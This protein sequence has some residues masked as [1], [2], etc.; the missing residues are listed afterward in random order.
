MTAADVNIG[1]GALLETFEMMYVFLV[2]N[3]WL[4]I[5]LTGPEGFSHFYTS[6][7]S[8]INLIKLLTHP[9]QASHRQRP[10]HAYVP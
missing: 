10:H 6:A 2:L 8:H 5:H 1:I 7:P 3:L 4:L 9:S